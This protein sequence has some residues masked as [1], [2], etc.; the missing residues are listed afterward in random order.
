MNKFDGNCECKK[1]SFEIAQE[2]KY[3]SH[4]H[5]SQCRKSHGS[6]F[7]SFIEVDKSCFK[8]NSGTKNIKSY[9]SSE[10][11]KRIFCQSC[12]SNIMFLDET[13]PDK[14]YVSVGAINGNPKLPKAH[15]VFVG[16]KASWYDIKDNLKQHLEYP[17]G[18]K[19]E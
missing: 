5:C 2:I 12:G 1:V 10:L 15:H 6:A 8:Y 9:S 19:N 3:F 14:Y 7:G 17:R 4:C 18:Y 16:S 13:N 11:C